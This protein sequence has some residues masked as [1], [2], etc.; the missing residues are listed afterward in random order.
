MSD[1]GIKENGTQVDWTY[2]PHEDKW[3]ISRKATNVKEL[4]E[5]AQK[6]RNE[7]GTEDFG[8]GRLVATIPEELFYQANAGLTYGGKYKGFMGVTG[9]EGEKLLSLF[10]QEP[11]ISIFMLNNNYRV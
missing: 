5:A 3:Y 9:E 1:F 10:L 2:Q 11:E 7:G 4:A 8:D 6:T